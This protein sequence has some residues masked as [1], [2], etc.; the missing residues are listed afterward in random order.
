[1]CV[2][3]TPTCMCTHL[4]L[5]SYWFKGQRRTSGTINHPF[6][7]FSF[8]FFCEVVSLAAFE[9]AK[10]A[11]LASQLGLRIRLPPV[12]VLYMHAS[13]LHMGSS[14]LLIERAPKS[15][16]SCSK[17]FILFLTTHICVHVCCGVCACE[18]RC[19]GGQSCWISQS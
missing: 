14:T 1:M 16:H 3:C 4:Q 12:L 13:T 9:L 7:S 8:F 17:R 6:F 10:Q 19:C 18:H 2:V 15:Q 5:S 11:R